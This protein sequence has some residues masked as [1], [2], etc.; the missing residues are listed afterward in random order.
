[1]TSQASLRRLARLGSAL[2]LILS[3]VA[4]LSIVLRGVFVVEVLLGTSLSVEPLDEFNVRYARRPWLTLVH[5]AGGLLF[6]ITGP[7]QFSP[8]LR[9]RSLALHRWSGRIFLFGSALAVGSALVFVIVL[10]VFGGFSATAGTSLGAVLFIIALAE[11]WRCIRRRDVRSH[12]EWML[13]AYAIG[14]GIATFRI[15]LALF[16]APPLAVP[17]VEAW[18]TVAWLGFVLNLIVAETWINLSRAG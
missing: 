3:L 16:T 4:L 2:V 12:R 11:A 5:L 15:L 18:D 10:P 17:F 8:S 9:R 1:M 7:L 14:L 13:R 6:L